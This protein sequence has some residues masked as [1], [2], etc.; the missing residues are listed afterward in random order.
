MY[1]VA[2]QVRSRIIN[3]SAW[4]RILNMAVI[5][6]PVI[7][8][9]YIFFLLCESSALFFTLPK[10]WATAPLIFLCWYQCNWRQP[11]WYIGKYLVNLVSSLAGYR[12]SWTIW[13]SQKPIIF[14]TNINK[15]QSN[16]SNSGHYSCPRS[17]YCRSI[18]FLLV[19]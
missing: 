14:C 6:R 5:T 3:L 15:I 9:A 11:Y 12:N 4:L 1:A 10:N 7:F 18:L 2:I 8:L 13:A 19:V 17:V 16:T